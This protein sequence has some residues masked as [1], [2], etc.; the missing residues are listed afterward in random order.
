MTFKVLGPCG[1]TAETTQL[2][3]RLGVRDLLVGASAE[4]LS[5]LSTIMGFSECKNGARTILYD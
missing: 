5:N 3:A 4:V 1:T 2:A